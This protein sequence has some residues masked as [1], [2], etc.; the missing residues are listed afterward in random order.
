LGTIFAL[1]AI[2][3]ACVSILVPLAAGDRPVQVSLPDAPQQQVTE[4]VSPSPSCTDGTSGGNVAACITGRYRTAAFSGAVNTSPSSVFDI[5]LYF[6]NISDVQLRDVSL[7]VE[8]PDD[9][10]YV[11]GTTWL[12]TSSGT[13][14][15]A[16]G[17]SDGGVIIGGYLPGGDAY[18]KFSARTSPESHYEC[19][20]NLSVV[21]L[22]VTTALGQRVSALPVAIVQSC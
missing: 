5:Q 13:H 19:G 2:L 6:K 18:M 11:Q 22:R 10:S 12:H 3:V 15:V 17:V 20:E 1:I 21:T 9:V 8:L 14:T 16:D 7:R 4:D